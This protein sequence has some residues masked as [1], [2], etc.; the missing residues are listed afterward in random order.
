[1]K[2]FAHGLRYTLMY[3]LARG[4]TID[5]IHSYIIYGFAPRE[6]GGRTLS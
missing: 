6:N 3:V 1:M 2:R 5:N 4:F